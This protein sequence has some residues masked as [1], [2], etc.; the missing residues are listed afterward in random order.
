MEASPG[1]RDGNRVIKLRLQSKPVLFVLGLIAAG[2]MVLFINHSYRHRFVRDN[3]DLLGLLPGGDITRFYADVG[4]LR[5]AGLLQVL[6]GAKPAGDAEYKQFVRETEF[7]YTKD[8]EAVAGTTGGEQTFLTVRG[9][10]DW[11]KLR[12]YASAHGGSCRQAVC[13][14]SAS[15]PGRWVSFLEVQPDVMAVALSPDASTVE[16]LKPTQR[17][18]G[19]PIPSGQPVWVEVSHSLLKAPLTL[20]LEVRIFAVTLQSADNAIFSLGRSADPNRAAFNVQLDAEC[21]NRATA[22]SVRNQ[23]EI[24]TKMLSLEL[25]REHAK[26]DAADL[27]G[28]LTD[29]SFQ[30][31]GNRV[32]GTWPV[33]KQ[34][35]NT[36]Q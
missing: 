31:E 13:S 1:G 11:S 24:Q 16:Q 17:V 19:Q 6:S 27:T 34:L 28:L 21:P 36:L 32:V 26:P 22:E 5:N 10:F 33:R 23:L 4:A 35:L 9:R 12:Q 7:D 18:E 29:G 2:G 30:M 14:V 25:T 15:K 8:L 20:P 3:H